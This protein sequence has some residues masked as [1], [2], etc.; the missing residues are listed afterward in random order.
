MLACGVQVPRDFADFGVEGALGS[1]WCGVERA[2]RGAFYCERGVQLEHRSA[3][4]RVVLG[5][6]PGA[7]GSR[8][9]ASDKDVRLLV[10]EN[11]SRCVRCHLSNAVRLPA[12]VR[13]LVRLGGR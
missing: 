11:A 9:V 6:R 10:G 1:T 8:G 3:A 12:A 13:A 7:C 2:H 5:V 4:Q